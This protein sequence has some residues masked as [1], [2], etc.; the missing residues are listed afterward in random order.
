[1]TDDNKVMTRGPYWAVNAE[2]CCYQCGNATLVTGLI[3][4]AN[5]PDLTDTDEFDTAFLKY[6]ESLPDGLLCELREQNATLDYRETKTS[7]R[8]YLTQLCQHCGALLGDWF[9]SKPGEAFW[10]TTA[11]EDTIKKILL[12]FDQDTTVRASPSYGVAAG[13]L[14]DSLY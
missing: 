1:M 5:D 10:P 4:Q 12:Q 9:L 8:T 3:C 7:G 11:E 2:T 13:I 14:D 6:I